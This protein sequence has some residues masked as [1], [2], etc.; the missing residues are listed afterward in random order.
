[1]SV[2]LVFAPSACPGH[3]LLSSFLQI[4]VSWLFVYIRHSAMLR[5]AVCF[6][7]CISI[8]L[9]ILLIWGGGGGV[10]AQIATFYC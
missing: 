6:D 10:H 8:R 5:H 1:M 7:G 3:C 4:H 9:K 2:F